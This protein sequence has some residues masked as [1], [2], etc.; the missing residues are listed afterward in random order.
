VFTYDDVEI[1]PDQRR[2]LVSNKP[3]SLGSRAYEVLEVLADAHGQLV[4]KDEIMRRVWPNRVVEENNV[5]V[6]IVLQ[7]NYVVAKSRRRR[8]RP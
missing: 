6:H 7:W 1:L 8:G 3:F 4:S 2:V 5:H